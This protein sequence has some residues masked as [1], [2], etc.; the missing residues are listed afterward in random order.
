LE[1]SNMATPNNAAR[2]WSAATLTALADYLEQH[3]HIPTREKLELL[4]SLVWRALDADGSPHKQVLGPLRDALRSLKRNT[5]FH[6]TLEEGIL[7]PFLRALESV[8]RGSPPLE[9]RAT[10]AEAAR[11]IAVQ[12]KE[13]DKAMAHIRRLAAGYSPPSD[14][15]EPFR[16]LCRELDA[17]DADLREHIR[18]ERDVL[19]PK[20]VALVPWISPEF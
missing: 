20:A 5:G 19:F 12:H 17:L 10:E 1:E 11:K 3:H 7:F 2:D 18:L 16:A 14:A 13:L 8:T 15:S 9:P 4:R 6:F